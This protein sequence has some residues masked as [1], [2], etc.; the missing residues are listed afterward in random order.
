V[1]INDDPIWFEILKEFMVENAKSHVSTE[2]FF[3]KVKDKTG[4]DYSYFSEQY[5]YSP[6]QPQLE[7]YQTDFS[8]LL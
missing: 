7:Y 1:S 8:F 6:N 4:T 5:L 2:D 3:D